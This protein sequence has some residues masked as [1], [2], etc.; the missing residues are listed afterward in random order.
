MAQLLTP[1][2][3][4]KKSPRVPCGPR[5]SEGSGFSSRE[6]FVSPWGWERNENHKNCVRLSHWKSNMMQILIFQSSFHPQKSISSTKKNCPIRSRHRAA[7][8]AVCH[9]G[10]PFLHRQMA[11]FF[12]KKKE[13]NIHFKVLKSLSKKKE[14]R[15]AKNR[16][17]HHFLF[18]HR[19]FANCKCTDVEV[20]G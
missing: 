18:C 2:R 10:E 9:C 12:K 20:G 6:A 7:G 5:F 13:K 4:K 16:L 19:L 15:L 17:V 11:R 3:T 14:L 1:K 8:P